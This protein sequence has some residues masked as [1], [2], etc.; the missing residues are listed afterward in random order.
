MTLAARLNGPTLRRLFEGPRRVWLFIAALGG[1]RRRVDRQPELVRARGLL[2]GRLPHLVGARAGLLSRRGLRVHLHFRKQAHTLS[3]SE[4]GLALGLFF[5]SPRTSL[6]P[7]S[8]ERPR[9]SSSTDA[10]ARSSSRSTW[11]S[12]RSAPASACSSSVARAGG[13]AGPHVWAVTML[14]AAAAHVLGIVLVSTVI[15]V[16]EK[17][18]SAPQ[19]PQTLLISLVGAVATTC[20]GL[21]AVVLIDRDPVERAPARR[22]GDRV[23]LRVSRVHGAARAAGARRVPVRVDAGHAGSARVRPGRRPAARVGEAAPAR[24]VRRDPAPLAG[25]RAGRR[26]AASPSTTARC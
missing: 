12:C 7:T 1:E 6:S 23:R 13:Q 22:A 20:L 10:S 8:W 16:A 2:A 14:A 21:A 9:R 11:R 4:V 19:L 3:L 5:A 15:A 18:V 25:H 17:R 24:R 26:S